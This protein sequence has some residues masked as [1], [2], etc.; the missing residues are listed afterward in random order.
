MTRALTVAHLT[1]IDLPPPQ[2]IEAAAE[3]GFDGVGLRLIKVTE[4]SPGYPLMDDPALLKQTQA[5]LAATGL[6]VPDIEFLKITP[7]T[8]VATLEPLLDAGAALGAQTLITAPYDDDLDRLA[9]RLAAI[10]E[11]AA[12]RGIRPVLEFFPWTVVPDLA[13]CWQVVQKAGPQVGLL[14]DSLHMDRSR[15]DLALLKAIPAERMPFAHLC[16]AMVQGSYT[17]EELL[18]TARAERLA[19]GTGEID[20]LAF[21]RALPSEIPL[22][23]EVP[24]AALTKAEGPEAVLRHIAKATRALLA[25]V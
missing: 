2:F 13:T 5:A 19:P 25:Q 12:P 11:L 14:A 20:L 6:K 22:G 3:A 4:D 21:L 7:E 18:F 23:L 8:D 1:A 10:A 15:S 16:D 24:M 9:D 17:T